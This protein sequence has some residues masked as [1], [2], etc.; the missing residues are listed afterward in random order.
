MNRYLLVLVVVALLALLQGCATVRSAV[1]PFDVEVPEPV[2]DMTPPEELS[3]GSLYRDG[4]AVELVGDFRAR[5]KG[6]I[7]TVLIT[8]SALGSS[9]ADNT[10]ERDSSTSLLAPTILGWENSARGALGPDFDPAT[11]LSA[12]SDSSFSGEG[13]TSRKSS[14]SATIAVRVVGVGRAGQMVVAGS[15]KVQVNREKQTITIAG[16]I[17]PE[18]VSSANTIASTKISDL[19]VIYGGSGE[20]ADVTKQGWFQRLMNKIWPL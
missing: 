20:I 10:L 18:D 19:S 14:L 16:I 8:E 12:T 13:E 6:D 9:A 1:D 15:K 3:E 2:V 5:H 17:R 4:S 7:I 11:A